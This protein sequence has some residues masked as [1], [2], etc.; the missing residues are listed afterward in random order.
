MFRLHVDIPLGADEGAAVEAAKAIMVR[1]TNGII[2]INEYYSEDWGW[3]EGANWRLG[4]D[5]D[6]QPSNYLVKTDAGHVTH[7]K[8]RTE[9]P[10]EEEE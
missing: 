3:V 5:G 2:A 9:F 6:R 8:C 7:K 1:L 4:R 10:R